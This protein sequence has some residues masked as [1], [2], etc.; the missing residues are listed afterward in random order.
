[1][2]KLKNS[3]KKKNQKKLMKMLEGFS[4]F[5]PIKMPIQLIGC[6]QKEV[7]WTTDRTSN[8]GVFIFF[9]NFF[10]GHMWL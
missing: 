6:R 1:M 7:V 4:L 5:S 10:K 9:S 8:V 3:L 2:K